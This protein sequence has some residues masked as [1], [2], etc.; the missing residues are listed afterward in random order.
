[1]VRGRLVLR[2]GG[3]EKTENRNAGMLLGIVGME[4]EAVSKR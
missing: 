3:G 2:R 4:A 1:M